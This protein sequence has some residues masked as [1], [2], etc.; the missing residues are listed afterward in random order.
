[1][2]IFEK[3]PLETLS[4]AKD[5]WTPI[6]LE[7]GRLEVDDSSIKWIGADGMVYRLPVATLSAV[8]LGPGTTITH[9]AMKACADSNTPVCW[10]GEDGLRFYAFGLAPN[11][12]ND[13]PRLHAALWADKKRRTEIA[14]RMFKMRFPDIAVESR[15]IK[16][17][18][19]ME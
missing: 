15:S 8:V 6:Y 14:R 4:P 7:H 17:L 18:R 19:G 2:P 3:P 11:H 5:R 10:M 16:E 1:M 13:M 9:A 12:A